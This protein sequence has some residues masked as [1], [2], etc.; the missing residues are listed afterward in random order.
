[1]NSRACGSWAE[2]A[3]AVLSQTRRLA[4]NRLSPIRCPPETSRWQE[5]RARLAASRVGSFSEKLPWWPG[6]ASDSP[7]ASFCKGR[8]MCRPAPCASEGLSPTQVSLA[9]A[10]G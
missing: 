8:P 3:E 4:K 6:G 5:P 1:M 9:C 10:L 2:T 7:R